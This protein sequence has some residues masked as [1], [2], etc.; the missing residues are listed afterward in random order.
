[1]SATTTAPLLPVYPRADVTFV[2]GDGCV[3]RD[4]AGREYL[5]FGAGI[6]VTQLGH[7]HPAVLA[8]AHAQ[9]DRIW[10]VSNLFRSEPQEP[11]AAALS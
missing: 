11:L 7:R 8:A 9:L 3:L 5:D 6:A 4:A 1:M 10:H 2:E